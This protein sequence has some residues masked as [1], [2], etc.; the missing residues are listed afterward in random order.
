ME[1]KI[2][3][4]VISYHSFLLPFYSKSGEL[5]AALSDQW[6][7]DTLTDTQI[8]SKKE[9]R[10]LD[11][12]TAQYFTPEAQRL[13]FSSESSYRYQLKGKDQF[14]E[15]EKD[16]VKYRLLVKKI[17]V[18]VF[19][20]NIG[21]LALHTE[22]HLKHQELGLRKMISDSEDRN[23]ALLGA[24]R[25]INEHGRRINL[26]YLGTSGPDENGEYAYSHSLVAD[27]I[28]LFGER[29][30]FA[31]MSKELYLGTGGYP[32]IGTGGSPMSGYIMKPISGL[33][34]SLFPQNDPVP[35]IDD[36]MYVCCLV[37]NKEL[38][39]RIK[40]AS[41]EFRESKPCEDSQC[42][43]P[44]AQRDLFTDPEL[45][46]A[47]YAI[48][49]IDKDEASC[50][51]E[52]RENILRRCVYNRWQ[53][54]GTIDVVTHHSFVRIVGDAPDY[55]IAPF[56]T[57]Y[58][59]MAIGALMQRAEILWLSNKSAEIS[60]EYFKL[61]D[62]DKSTDNDG[63]N[64][65]LTELKRRYVYAQNN[66]FLVQLTVQEQGVEEFEMLKNELYVGRSLK[67]LDGSI[68]GIYEFTR[69]YAEIEEND[70]LSKIAKIGLPLALIQALSVI[71]SFAVISETETGPHWMTL[72]I[73]LGVFAVIGVISLLFLKWVMRKKKRGKG[74]D[75]KNKKS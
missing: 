71:T 13:L 38:S 24:V 62:T 37:D 51:L 32:M 59:Y 17:T 65:R 56:V 34:R 19:D 50:G 75:R 72:L 57:Q 4:K 20:K 42:A 8:S 16:S 69:E 68:N 7:K 23:K 28:S 48:C 36:R 70:L 11:Y 74:A 52:M 22:F 31:A 67:K 35:V 60:R 47:I 3:D 5:H 2:D 49:F 40:R 29:E 46:E 73:Q 21:V 39:D 41:A 14:Y 61:S 12:A 63:V 9:E 15:I 10:K 53:Q 55:V 6:D 18:T 64:D 44:V 66:I 33:L 26:P 27:T 58:V 1:P 25:A 30:D 54:E 45:S 43:A